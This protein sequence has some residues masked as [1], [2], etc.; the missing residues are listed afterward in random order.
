MKLVFSPPIPLGIGSKSEYLDFQLMEPVPLLTV[1][2]TLSSFL[3]EGFEITAMKRI[4]GKYRSPGSLITAAEYI[5]DDVESVDQLNDYL[6][7][8]DTVYS[9]SIIDENR[10]CM[11]SDPN[12]GASRPDRV[13]EAAGVRWGS[14]TRSNIFI[15]DQAGHFVPLLAV[16]EG[17]II[18]EG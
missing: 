18:N 14:I 6:R 13:M 1:F 7:E 15:T 9:L 10:V 4:T 16:T 11:V 5:I 12:N 3:P 17:E 8:N 2:K